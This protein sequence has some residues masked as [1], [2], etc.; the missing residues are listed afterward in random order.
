MQIEGRQRQ[1][2]ALL[3]AQWHENHVQAQAQ[4][5]VIACIW[6]GVQMYLQSDTQ[7]QH[8]DVQDKLSRSR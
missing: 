6:Q 4:L 3:G 2:R 5:G 8:P 1:Q 7:S